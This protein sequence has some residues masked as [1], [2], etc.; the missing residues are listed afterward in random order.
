MFLLACVDNVTR[1]LNSLFHLFCLLL[2]WPDGRCIEFI[3]DEASLI[4]ILIF[5]MQSDKKES[6]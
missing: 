3:I 1:Y 5:G 2:L 4:Y 6:L